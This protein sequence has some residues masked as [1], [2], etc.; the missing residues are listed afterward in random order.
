MC[1]AESEGGSSTDE[2]E[3]LSEAESDISD[4]G[5]STKKGKPGARAVPPLAVTKRSIVSKQGKPSIR[6]APPMK[7]LP[8]RKTPA[9]NQAVD[10]KAV[11]PKGQN[12][13]SLSPQAAATKGMKVASHQERE[14]LAPKADIDEDV[15]EEVS[16]YSQRRKEENI[17]AMLGRR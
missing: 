15:P 3:A 10:G 8:Q 14:N 12:V 2:D 5:I 17:K 13:S 1:A 11:A 9:V 7:V 4:L 16:E 6:S